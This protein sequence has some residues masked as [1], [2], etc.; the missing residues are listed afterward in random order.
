MS[1]RETDLACFA[2]LCQAVEDNRT[3]TKIVDLCSNSLKLTDARASQIGQ[4]LRGNT[5]VERLVIPVKNMTLNGSSGIAHFISSNPNLSAIKMT[6]NEST[7]R[8]DVRPTVAVVDRFLVSAGMNGSIRKLEIPGSFG[9]HALAFSLPALRSSL[10]SLNMKSPRSTT[11]SNDDAEMLGKAIS[12]LRCLEELFFESKD[13]NFAIPFLNRL[14]GGPPTLRKLRIQV[15]WINNATEPLAQAIKTTLEAAPLLERFTLFPR[16]ERGNP[17]QESL[18]IIFEA[19]KR[20]QCLYSLSFSFGRA[21]V[22]CGM[23]HFVSL[24]RHKPQLKFLSISC[25]NLTDLCRVVEEVGTY[26]M[27]KKLEVVVQSLGDEESVQGA[28]RR[29]GALIPRISSLEKLTIRMRATVPTAPAEFV[30][31]FKLNTS[32]TDVTL[33]WLRGDARK[34]IDLYTMRNRYKPHLDKASLREMLGIFKSMLETDGEPERGLSVVY[35]T[36]RSRDKWYEQS[37]DTVGVKETVAADSSQ[38]DNSIYLLVWSP[39][40]NCD[41]TYKTKLRAGDL[42]SSLLQK[43]ISTSNT[44]SD[45]EV[46][47]QKF[48]GVISSRG[49]ERAPSAVLTDFCKPNDILM[50]VPKVATAEECFRVAQRILSNCGIACNVRLFIMLLKSSN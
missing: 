46:G 1:A 11:T 37:T 7:I 5:C 36:L 42:V 49:E 10:V 25:N 20:H 24:L 17:T 50:A 30:G 27:V 45:S 29:L 44:R 32:L 15:D 2:S 40:T 48:T 31:G 33:E 13:R 4:A 18:D 28:L 12:S 16:Q 6:D 35:E 26:N 19:V 38:V 47:F 39:M 22:D 34:A 43:I 14:D 41:K 8:V 21:V 23:S 9:A 3:D